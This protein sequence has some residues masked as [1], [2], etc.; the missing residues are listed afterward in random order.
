MPAAKTTSVVLA[1]PGLVDLAIKYADFLKEKYDLYKAMDKDKRLFK[2]AVR[3]AQGEVSEVLNFYKENAASVTATF[4]D[5][6]EQLS[7]A[8]RDSAESITSLLTDG[9]TGVLVQ[10]GYSFRGA[11]KIS[12]SCAEL[13]KWVKRF[14]E[15]AIIFLFFGTST[16]TATP[17]AGL[18]SSNTVTSRI[19]SIRSADPPAEA[20]IKSLNIDTEYDHDEAVTPVTKDSHIWLEKNKSGTNTLGEYR[21]YANSADTPAINATRILV[22]DLA[23]RLRQ[24]DPSTMGILRC[25]GFS[26]NLRK[27]LFALHFAYPEGQT[28]PKALQAL[29][30]ID[31]GHARPVHSLTERLRLAKGI[32]SALFYIHAGGFVHKQINP[33]N[34]LVF[35]SASHT[36]PEHLGQPYLVGFDAVR[37]ADA[38]SQLLRET[39]WKKNIYQHPDRQHLKVG[40]EFTMR[41]DVYS[42]GVVLLEIALWRLFTDPRGGQKHLWNKV[43]KTKDGQEIE[44]SELLSPDAQRVQYKDL[45]QKQIPPKFGTKYKDVVL[46]CLDGLENGE[47]QRKLQDADG[48]VVGVAYIEQVM[49]RLDQIEL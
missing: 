4:A 18:A 43:K 20:E 22:R 39:D 31:Q 2:L 11:R 7:Q 1:I 33:T 29:M 13:E 37:K 34:V 5:D 8:I 10:V 28:S 17:A 19:R 49:D 9:E 15:R 12:K 14:L 48:I 38:R 32:A 26:Q 45:A 16:S 46:A 6:L 27:N 41:H 47:E 40:H 42:L 36:Y 3:C 23:A 24:A 25:L 44:E 21:K 35:E 30:E